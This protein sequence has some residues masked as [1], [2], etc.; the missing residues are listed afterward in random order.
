M[1]LTHLLLPT[2]VHLIMKRVILLFLPAMGVLASILQFAS[3]C[4]RRNEIFG[5]P[6]GALVLP[7]VIEVRF[8]PEVLPVVG[9]HASISRVLCVTEGA[10]HCFEVKHIKV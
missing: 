2:G 5:F 9:V 10:P 1:L 6:I 8:P 7:V 3:V 4:I